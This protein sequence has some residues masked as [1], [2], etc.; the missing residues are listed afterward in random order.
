[1][2]KLRSEVRILELLHINY[3]L[4][5]G[6]ILSVLIKGGILI[7]ELVLYT[8]GTMHSVLYLCC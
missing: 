4:S 8:S 6:T 2:C 3:T 5:L 7:S 1:M